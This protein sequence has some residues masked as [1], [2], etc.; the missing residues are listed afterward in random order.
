MPVLEVVL[1]R[2]SSA[3]EDHADQD[4]AS[5]YELGRSG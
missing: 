4:L 2:F 5:V 1:E 3:S